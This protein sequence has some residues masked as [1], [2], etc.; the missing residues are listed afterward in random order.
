MS[1]TAVIVPS[2][3]VA[4][5]GAS[6]VKSPAANYWDNVNEPSAPDDAS[7]NQA[8]L[9]GTFEC[10]CTPMPTAI[11]VSSLAVLQRVQLISGGSAQRTRVYLKIGAS[12][13]YGA[14]VDISS[15]GS[16]TNFTTTWTTNP[17]T[18]LP[19]TP[20]A[21]NSL[22]IGWEYNQSS[23]ESAKI[24]QLKGTVTY[25]PLPPAQESARDS[26]SR[27][28]FLRRQ[29]Q[30]FPEIS[31]GLWL[32]D[33][34][35]HTSVDLFH[36]FGVSESGQGWERSSW[37]R[38]LMSVAA[39]TV[40]P[41]KN[42]VTLRLRNERRIRCLLYDSGWAKQ[43]TVS[44]NGLMKFS[45]GATWT[46][47]RTSEATFTDYSGDSVTVPTNVEAYA[48]EGQEFLAAAGA[49]TI[50]RG[51][52]SNNSTGRTWCAQQMSARFE[53][54]PDWNAA[55]VTTLNLTVAYVYHD[56][57]NYAWVY[58]DGA[59]ARWVFELRVAGT[60]Y[61][62][63]KSASP[64]ANTR[65]VIGVRVTGSHGELGLTPYTASIFVDGVKG[66]D[67]VAGAAM[68]EAASSTFD[69]GTK[70]GTD[71]FKGRIRRRISRQI[72]LTDTEMARSF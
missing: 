62:A 56:A 64:V 12:Y 61:R 21:I 71:P 52:W 39:V 72:V 14:W 66:T 5:T 2:A 44:K 7:Y 45:N 23:S 1:V 53:V 31:G 54:M 13:Y 27:K 33:L 24:T 29:P 47:T 51:Y 35:H 68:T 43:G 48:A 55:A 60:I 8:G 10:S 30:Q 6:W 28:L 19:F 38:G 11:S 32:L 18:G 46:F 42:Q 16:L 41:M 50:D 59:N 57:N 22:L 4:S 34:A 67:V 15:V 17:A 65:Y 70:A 36:L 25:V 69:I 58:F 40:D 3:D 9:D 37:K 20:A 49:R 26:A 63:V